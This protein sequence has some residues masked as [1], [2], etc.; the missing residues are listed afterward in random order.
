VNPKHCTERFA[1]VG[2]DHSATVPT[3]KRELTGTIVPIVRIGC[4]APMKFT[5]VLLLTLM[6]F[7]G[8]KPVVLSPPR[9]NTS[10]SPT[11]GSVS[12]LDFKNGIGDLKL[13]SPES[14][15]ANRGFALEEKNVYGYA[16]GKKYKN[17]NYELEFGDCYL[18]DIELSF[19][20]GMLVEIRGH[21]TTKPKSDASRAH[22]SAKSFLNLLFGEATGYGGNSYQA[23]LFSESRSEISNSYDAWKGNK[24]EMRLERFSVDGKDSIISLR[25]SDFASI[26]ALEDQISK[27]R[28]QERE[29]RAKAEK[30]RMLKQKF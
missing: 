8:C 1:Q 29:Q 6:L 21:V 17:G 7:C 18:R 24:V 26:S 22:S 23:R 4:L 5:S 10:P 25:L 16:G 9:K 2:S 30:E 14:Q 20:D 3:E 13:G 11:P 28:Q 19:I 12:H 27:R 15:F